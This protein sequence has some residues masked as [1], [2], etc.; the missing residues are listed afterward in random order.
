MLSLSLRTARLNQDY[1]GKTKEKEGEVT[2]LLSF[3]V[4]EIE[5]DESELGAITGEAHAYRALVDQTKDGPRPV[6]SCFKP[7][8]LVEDIEN[9]AVTVRLRGGAEYKFAGCHLSKNRVS[10]QPSGV[11]TLSVK[12]LATPALDASLADFVANMGELVDVE[13]HG[14]QASDQKQLPLN[15]H[16]EGEQPPAG[17]RR[18]RNGSRP[19]AH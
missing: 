9:V 15:T 14:A 11:P 7:F 12:I 18:S 8:Q 17:K 6:F 5:L 2:K 1:N 19:A 4:D 10:V 13:I 16:G 3:R